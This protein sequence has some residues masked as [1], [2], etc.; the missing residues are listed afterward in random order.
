[1]LVLYGDF[2]DPAPRWPTIRRNG[3]VFADAVNKAGGKV[4]RSAQPKRSRL[5][6]LFPSIVIG[7]EAGATPNA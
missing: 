4:D 5:N 3:L 7:L 1:V 6:P 2:I